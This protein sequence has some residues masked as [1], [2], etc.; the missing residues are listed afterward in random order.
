MYTSWPLVSLEKC[1]KEFLDRVLTPK[2]GVNAEPKKELMIV[3]YL[4]GLDDSTTIF[5]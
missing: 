3:Q 1:I 2:I 5:G 4:K